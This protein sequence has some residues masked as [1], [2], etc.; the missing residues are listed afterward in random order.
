MYYIVE[1]EDDLSRNITLISLAGWGVRGRF[2]GGAGSTHPQ[3]SK[4]SSAT[5]HEYLLY[6]LMYISQWVFKGTVAGDL[7]HIFYHPA[8]HRF[9]SY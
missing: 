2:T 1:P 6:L 4:Y 9:S 7:R 3:L 5:D 8:S